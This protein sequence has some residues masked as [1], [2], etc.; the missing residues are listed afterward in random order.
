MEELLH[1]LTT[2]DYVALGVGAA[3]KRRRVEAS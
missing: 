1:Q 2:S 3:F